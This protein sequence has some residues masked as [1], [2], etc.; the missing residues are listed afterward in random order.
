MEKRVYNFSAGPAIL[1]EEVL[2]EAQKDLFALP[3]VGMSILEI[4]HRSKAFDKII[5]E[6]KENLKSLLDV[7]DNYEILFLQSGA[8]LQFSMVPMNL[9]PPKNKADYIITGS[10]SKKALKEAKR[11]GGVNI[12]ATTEDGN[13]KRIPKQ[14]ELKLDSDA[15]YVHFTSNNTIYGTQW[16]KEPE[17]GNV[18]LV[19]DAS[20]D[21]LSKKID[22]SKYGVIYAG[23]QKNMGPS[24]V[25]TIII[26]KDL[27]ERSQDSLPTMLNY[28]T[29]VEGNSLYN[30]PNTFGVYIIGL[31]A[32]WI[33]HIGGLEVMEKVN[34]EKAE[35]LYKCID[36]SNGFFKGHAEKDSRSLMNV[37]FNLQT[38]ELEKMLVTEAT[39]AGFDGVKGHRSVGGL[40]A[41]IYNAFPKKG[42]E[43]LVDFMKKFQA[44]HS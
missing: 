16:K 12:A 8:S 11:V 38:E 21:I 10:W 29:H 15:S 9:M 28:K 3:G 22:V 25:T 7:S 13:F 20:S 26:R 32:K 23:A 33:K 44:K 1:P 30:T 27:T 42:V 34:K 36:E 19:C 17:T 6:A 24:G 41:S 39:A 14:E 4:S 37:T 43:D 40:R 31:V 35:I 2:L 5:L 18:P